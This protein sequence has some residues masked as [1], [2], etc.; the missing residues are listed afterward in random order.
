LEP[1]AIETGATFEVQIPLTAFRHT[2]Q[3]AQIGLRVE[4]PEGA[5]LPAWISFDPVRGVLSGTA[6]GGVSDFT[7]VVIANDERGSEIKAPINLHFSK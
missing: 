3:N 1:P 5:S 6:P 7:V 4:L 2:N